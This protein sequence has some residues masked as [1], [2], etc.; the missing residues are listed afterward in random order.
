MVK[1][2]LKRLRMFD[3]SGDRDEDS[4]WNR[5]RDS[6]TVFCPDCGN[7]YEYSEDDDN[8]CPVC[9]CEYGY[10]IAEEESEEEGF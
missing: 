3:E 6:F 9:G 1:D 2:G 8:F 10:E 7:E 4:F 5:D